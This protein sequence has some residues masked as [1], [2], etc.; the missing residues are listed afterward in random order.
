[1]TKGSPLREYRANRAPP[2]T[3]EQ[4]GELFGVN[5][6]TVLRWET[7]KVPA[8]RVIEVERATGVPRWELRP[9]LYPSEESAEARA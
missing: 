6:S 5:K 8:E 4:L 2:L 7:E 9:D 1:M 3:L